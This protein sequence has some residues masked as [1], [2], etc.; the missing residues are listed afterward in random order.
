MKFDISYIADLARLYL[1]SA[2]KKRLSP[3]LKSILSYVEKISELKTEN[4]PPTFQTIEV[5]DAVREDRV[6]SKQKLHQKEAL[7]NTS[8]KRKGFFKVPRIW[9]V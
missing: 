9:E 6:E 8:S 1:N 5:K 7:A 2:E 4:I 3:Q